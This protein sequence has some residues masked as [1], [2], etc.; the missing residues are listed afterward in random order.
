[1]VDALRRLSAIHHQQRHLLWRALVLLGQ[2]TMVCQP[3]AV[4]GWQSKPLLLP[5]PECS[6]AKPKQ[7]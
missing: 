4:P 3:D 1:M 6:V 5:L 7:Y 2:T